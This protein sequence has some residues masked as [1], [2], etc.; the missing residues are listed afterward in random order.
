MLKFLERPRSPKPKVRPLNR[1][2][3]ADELI[4]PVFADLVMQHG[5]TVQFDGWVWRVKEFS[6]DGLWLEPVRPN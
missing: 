1:H 3:T 4:L 2:V 6:M 5:A